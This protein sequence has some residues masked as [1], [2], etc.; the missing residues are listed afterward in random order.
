MKLKMKA[1]KWWQG[2]LIAIAGVLLAIGG[3]FL[4]VYFTTGIGAK[5]VYPENIAFEIKDANGETLE[6]YNEEL[7]QFEMSEDFSMRIGTQTEGVNQNTLT[8]SFTSNFTETAVDGYITNGVISIPQKVTIGQDFE[9]KVQQIDDWN[10]GG[11][12]TIYASTENKLLLPTSAKIAIDVPVKSIGTKIEDTSSSRV[13]EAKDGVFNIIKDTNVRIS[14]L[15]T[16]EDSQ[17][18]FSDNKTSKEDKRM[19]NFFIEVLDGADNFVMNRDSEGIYF[20]SAG[21]LDSTAKIKIYTFKNSKDQLDFYSTFNEG[22]SAE[23]IYNS[24]IVEL[25]QKPEKAIVVEANIKIVEA[26][27]SEFKVSRTQK[28]ELNTN[29]L[30]TIRANSNTY[31]NLVL[32]TTILDDMK[33]PVPAMISKVAMRIL[34]KVDENWVETD[35]VNLV[36]GNKASIEGANYTFINASV[37][38]LNNA[39]W[40]ISSKEDGAEYRAEIVLLV[41]DGGYKIFNNQKYGF[42]ISFKENVDASV[43]WKVDNTTLNMIVF[44]GES[45]SSTQYEKKL[46]ELISVPAQNVYQRVVY[47]AYTDNW[48]NTSEDEAKTYLTIKSFKDYSFSK[49]DGGTETIYM[50]ELDSPYLLIKKGIE[51]LKIRF[52]TVKTD[53]YGNVLLDENGKYQ[54]AKWSNDLTINALEMISGFSENNMEILT[55]NCNNYDKDGLKRY[56]LSKDKTMQF[57]IKLDAAQMPLFIKQYNQGLISFKV[58]DFENK[59]EYSDLIETITFDEETLIFTVKFKDSIATSSDRLITFKLNYNPTSD[60]SQS[61]EIKVKDSETNDFGY[62]TVYESSPKT[63]ENGLEESYSVKAEQDGSKW[64]IKIN[65]TNLDE[66]NNKISLTK[67]FDKYG[68]DVT[69]KFPINLSTSNSRIL[70]VNADKK[71]SFNNNLSD[72]T[73]NVTLSINSGS[74]EGKNVIFTFTAAK[75]TKIEYLKDTQENQE[76]DKSLLDGNIETKTTDLNS[77]TIRKLGYTGNIVTLEKLL[78]VYTG[79]SDTEHNQ[80]TNLSFRLRDIAGMGDNKEYL[81]GADGMFGMTSDDMTGTDITTETNIKSITVKHDFYGDYTLKMRVE[82]LGISI[83]LDI[84]FMNNVTATCQLPSIYNQGTKTVSKPEDVVIDN[85]TYTGVYADYK[86]DMNNF[87][88]V[89]KTKNNSSSGNSFLLWENGFIEGAGVTKSGATLTFDTV[90]SPTD[91]VFAIYEVANNPFAFNQSFRCYVYPNIQYTQEKRTLNFED[92]ASSGTQKIEDYFGVYKYVYTATES[93]IVEGLSYE[94]VNQNV[95]AVK[96]EKNEFKRKDKDKN[97]KPVK[98]NLYNGATEKAFEVSAM[99]NNAI[100]QDYKGEDIVIPMTL[101]LKTSYD[102]LIENNSDYLSKEKYDGKEV[103][104]LKYTTVGALQLKTPKKSESSSSETSNVSDYDFDIIG[105]ENTSIIQK[106]SEKKFQIIG[107]T[108]ILSYGSNFYLPITMKANINNGSSN[109]IEDVATFRIPLLISRVDSTYAYYKNYNGDAVDLKVLLSGATDLKNFPQDIYAQ[110]N[111]GTTQTVVHHAAKITSTGSTITVNGT[112][113]TWEVES[114]TLTLKEGETEKAKSEVNKIKIDGAEYSWKVEGEGESKTLVLTIKTPAQEGF[115][116]PSSGEWTSSLSVLSEQT[117]IK[118]TSEQIAGRIPGKNIT[119]KLTN[120]STETYSSWDKIKLGGADYTWTI[121]DGKLVLT[122]GSSSITEGE[123]G[124]VTVGSTIYDIS[125]WMLTE[126][127]DTGLVTID[128]EASKD[129]KISSL[130]NTDR[131]VVLQ[132]KLSQGANS[133][134]YIY[135]IKVTHDLEIS[136]QYPYGGNVEYLGVDGTLTKD[137]SALENGKQRFIVKENGV[138]KDSPSTNSIKSITVNNKE[139]TIGGALYNLVFEEKDGIRTYKAGSAVTIS[140]N[141]DQMTIS[142]VEKNVSVVMVKS[143]VGVVNGELEYSFLINVSDKKYVIKL[144]DETIDHNGTVERTLN[145]GG[146]QTFTAL[147]MTKAGSTET[148]VGD[149]V[150]TIISVGA[151]FTLETKT[152]GTYTLKG[153]KTL[154]GSEEEI[155]TIIYDPKSTLTITP[156]GSFTEPVTF[157]LLFTAQEMEDGNI[158]LNQPN[159]ATIKFTIDRTIKITEND[160]QLYGGK[161]YNFVGTTKDEAGISTTGLITEVL[162]FNTSDYGSYSAS[163]IEIECNVLTNPGTTEETKEKAEFV[164]VDNSNKTVTFA[165]LN[166]D[167]DVEFTVKIADGDSKYTF[168]FTRTLAKSVTYANDKDLA[169]NKDNAYIYNEKEEQTSGS[170]TIIDFDKFT[171]YEDDTGA[172]NGKFRIVSVNGDTI[173]DKTSSGGYKVEIDESNGQLTI[174]SE[175]VAIRQVR[176]Y[177]IEISYTFGTGENAFSYKFFVNVNL[178]VKPNTTSEVHYPSLDGKTELKYETVKADTISTSIDTTTDLTIEKTDGDNVLVSYINHIKPEETVKNYFVVKKSQLTG[179]SGIVKLTATTSIYSKSFDDIWENFF[180]QASD[181]NLKGAPRILFSPNNGMD[182]VEVI[183]A[184]DLNYDI[185]KDTTSNPAKYNVTLT[186]AEGKS[187][188]T[189][190]FNVKKNEVSAVYEVY[191]I[192]GE[193]YTINK[194]YTISAITEGTEKV[195]RFNR[196]SLADKKIFDK[197]RLIALD[198]PAAIDTALNGRVVTITYTYGADDKE[199]KTKFLLDTNK[200]G[201]T[202]YIEAGN[203]VKTIKSITVADSDTDY[204]SA[205]S[206]RTTERITL[207]YTTKEGPKQIAKNLVVGSVTK[208]DDKCICGKEGCACDTSSTCACGEGCSCKTTTFAIYDIESLAHTDITYTATFSLKVNGKE[209]SELNNKDYKFRQILDIAVGNSYE[210]S[211]IT[212]S[213]NETRDAKRDLVKLANIHHPSTNLPLSAEDFAKGEVSVSLSILSN[214]TS[215]LLTN[216][217]VYQNHKDDINKPFDAM[218]GVKFLSYTDMRVNVNNTAKTWNYLLYGEGATNNGS[219]ALLQFTY[220]VGET[221]TVSGTTKTFYIWVRILPD[222]D[223]KVDGTSITVLDGDTYSVSNNLNQPYEVTPVEKTTENPSAYNVTLTSASGSPILTIVDTNTNSSDKAFNWTYKITQNADINGIKYNIDL[224]KIKN[225]GSEISLDNP[226]STGNQKITLSPTTAAGTTT[227]QVVL[228]KQDKN[229]FGKKL[230]KIDVSNEYGYEAQIYISFLPENREDPTVHS[231]ST[232]NTITEGQY[233]DIGAVYTQLTLTASQKKGPDGNII[234][235][236]Y[237]DWD[238]KAVE[239]KA[240]DVG[241]NEADRYINIAGIDAWTYTSSDVTNAMGGQ[242][243]TVDKTSFP[244]I[245]SKYLDP[246]KMLLQYVTIQSIEYLYGENKVPVGTTTV[247]ETDNKDRLA[248]VSGSGLLIKGEKEGADK[249][250]LMK[251]VD[252][253]TRQMSDA[254][255]SVPHLADW[256]YSDYATSKNSTDLVPITMR[257]TLKYEKGEGS[258]KQTEQYSLTHDI[259]VK[260]ALE[261]DKT[262]QAVVKDGVAFELNKEFTVGESKE[263][264]FSYKANDTISSGI[265]YI[266]DTLVLTLPASQGKDQN[267]TVGIEVTGKEKPEETTQKLLA[268]G[269]FS[270]KNTNTRVTS[271]YNSIS[272][273]LKKVETGEGYLIKAGDNIKFTFSNFEN[274][275]SIIGG[276]DVDNEGNITKTYYYDKFYATYG[277]SGQVTAN[278]WYYS[279]TTKPATAATGTNTTTNGTGKDY[280]KGSSTGETTYT[281]NKTIYYTTSKDAE[282]KD[283]HT[284]NSF[285]GTE[286]PAGSKVTISDPT[287]FNIVSDP[288]CSIK[289]PVTVKEGTQQIEITGVP[290]S[291]LKVEYVTNNVEVK[292]QTY[293]KINIPTSELFSTTRMPEVTKS[294]IVTVAANSGLDAT[295]DHSYRVEKNWIVTPV[296]Y[297]ANSGLSQGS[298]ISARK[299]AVGVGDN[300]TDRYQVTFNTW[301]DEISYVEGVG[302]TNLPGKG[303]TQRELDATKLN[304]M[305]GNK[306]TAGTASVSGDGTVT[307]RAGYVAGSDEY[308]QLV[309]RVRASGVDGQFAHSTDKDYLLGNLRLFVTS[310]PSTSGS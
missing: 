201:L 145:P 210:N 255:F 9:V 121:T 233:F 117:L 118:L 307:T 34:K 196:D 30:Y 300:A 73:E 81:I 134:S 309:V 222:Y 220:T 68:I 304:I 140:F 251:Q 13:Y 147:T 41:S 102:A 138:P 234:S 2:L 108:E 158:I 8:L 211:F 238:F 240:S 19:K 22:I 290:V 70:E 277:M 181:L 165:M 77:V 92:I 97:G 25:S 119:L 126:A 101:S 99:Y 247:P 38:D 278:T 39:Y 207:S 227:K 32:G 148:G 150:S 223:F 310:S 27:V 203:I 142:T 235:G 98:L 242:G 71:I 243:L 170:E 214:V 33:E 48:R 87:F 24:A 82:G 303:Q 79:I 141:G 189:V 160:A 172:S 176:S 111:A 297:L 155:A 107:L 123:N 209:V 31:S 168:T 93:S 187:A 62:L 182:S 67:V 193:V 296:Y 257:I 75:V 230:Y 293:D 274:N 56:I 50:A 161:T 292:I 94:I 112:A 266:D 51:G 174:T 54:I 146:A 246:D 228:T 298:D 52:V 47:F 217:T 89:T 163:N 49:T 224:D 88:I 133:F 183:K 199:A 103:V 106:L 116:L 195:D 271:Y 125:Y 226:S 28:M 65:G 136:R 7:G 6:G 212:I 128:E 43:S 288:T 156:T 267:L 270:I 273:Y 21:A 144:G 45:A 76:N 61:Y 85:V 252:E 221:T 15:F 250:K 90:Y 295:N 63:I 167:K 205:W 135:R 265:S 284:Y 175:N 241:G 109:T 29:K 261:V 299:D 162:K 105:T 184:E 225:N 114:G 283:V 66:I 127:S 291:A 83:D 308:I 275:D 279:K 91:I 190:T 10:V 46:N 269:S 16:P 272:K 194:N 95:K 26:T 216:N 11:I 23:E 287:N 305:I 249:L 171:T 262:K 157:D 180:S 139:Y 264:Y 244:T 14:A 289:Y 69:E 151:G 40:E 37:R 254:I 173:I 285:A 245:E 236:Q 302:N 188:G 20:T 215:D 96:I 72:E 152:A 84:V 276:E 177:A 143:Y 12:A 5:K 55:T 263:K 268:R 200:K 204:T 253:K 248:S 197:D 131:F 286:I 198:I 219:W 132:L 231:S 35:E 239:T 120:S 153:K 301:S 78:K 192:A 53:A 282:D 4:Y 110:F 206:A 259:T 258:D 124:Q 260:R 294:Y 60:I 178:T 191:L 3:V 59:M 208:L 154:T 100:V 202:I 74:A 185:T 17:Y 130:A 166:E 104:M 149:N 137:L 80:Y 280:F 36:G 169:S 218:S 44:P 164:K 64:N 186:L 306:E 179:T 213:V 281:L 86:I 159:I 18:I 113:Y 58:L 232:L 1:L 229:I 57:K 115:Y 122:N 256:V 129:I 237:E 42:D